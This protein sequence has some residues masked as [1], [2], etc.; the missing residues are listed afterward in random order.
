MTIGS[1]D[2]GDWLR[3]ALDSRRCSLHELVGHS[4]KCKSQ[5]SCGLGRLSS[6]VLAQINVLAGDRTEGI[7][8]LFPRTTPLRVHPREAPL[9]RRARG[10]HTPRRGTRGR[11]GSARPPRGAPARAA[12]G[13]AC[14]A[15]RGAGGPARRRGA[16]A[17]ARGEIVVAPVIARRWVVGV[18]G[19]SLRQ[20]KYHENL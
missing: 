19:E 7:S 16:A 12:A 1:G 10:Q 14:G 9:R 6:T 4:I 13:A 20:N 2:P 5:P 18:G 15:G 8:E 17:A 3:A 11:R